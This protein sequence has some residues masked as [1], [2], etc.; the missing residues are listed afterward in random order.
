MIRKHLSWSR[1]VLLFLPRLWLSEVGNHSA[2][3]FNTKLEI[4]T[5]IFGHISPTYS[6]I[7][8]YTATCLTA[9]LSANL[10]FYESK[11]VKSS[12]FNF[13]MYLVYLE[14]CIH[15]SIFEIINIC[16]LIKSWSSVVFRIAFKNQMFSRIS[17]Q[18][19]FILNNF[20]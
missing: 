1:F 5:R 13:L 11:T 3:C 14:V 8:W 6:G 18:F 20:H 12:L 4:D 16:L 7:L 15:L 17:I 9:C 10:E 19:D 2:T